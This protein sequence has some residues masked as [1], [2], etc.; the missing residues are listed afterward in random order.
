MRCRELSKAPKFTVPHV[1]GRFE[2]LLVR[3]VPLC[4]SSTSDKALAPNDA[5]GPPQKLVKGRGLG[6]DVV[7]RVAP[8]A[9]KPRIRVL[10]RHDEEHTFTGF[11]MQTNVSPSRGARM[12]PPPKLVFGSCVNGVF[13]RFAH[14]VQFATVDIEPQVRNRQILAEQLLQITRAG[15]AL[16]LITIN[17]V[18]KKAGDVHI[19]K[20]RYPIK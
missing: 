10:G 15:V 12:F 9:Q 18:N 7:V 3:R 16:T 14:R 6:T 17:C 13:L 20:Q 8:H 1:H 19:E 2:V 11:G 4:V 5:P